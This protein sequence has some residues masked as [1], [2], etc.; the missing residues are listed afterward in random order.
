MP[1]TSLINNEIPTQ[2]FELVGERIGEILATELAYQKEQYDTPL[3]DIYYE[4]TVTFTDNDYPAL[5]VCFAALPFD[6]HSPT[7]ASGILSYNIDAYVSHPNTADDRGD[8]LAGALIKKLLGMCRYILSY[9]A[10]NTLGFAPG[11]VSRV[12]V[13]NIIIFNPGNTLDASAGIV[14]RLVLNARV[15]ETTSY[16]EVKNASGYLTTALLGQTD[17]GY[18]WQYI[19]SQ[20]ESGSSS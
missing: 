14:G 20:G 19:S 3:P 7:N 9:P 15:N 6:T 11:L 18:Q 13:G 12:Q 16:Q 1:A 17:K 4:R 5:N 8:E 2:L 10:Y